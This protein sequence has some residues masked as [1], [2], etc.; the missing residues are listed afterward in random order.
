MRKIPIFTLLAAILL[1]GG[2]YLY[3]HASSKVDITFNFVVD[4]KGT[5][6]TVTGTI[7]GAG[8]KAVT[9]PLSKES[10]NAVKKGNRY[11]VEA[12]FY[13]KNKI[14]SDE[15]KELDGP[16]WSNNS[17]QGLLVNKVQVENIQALSDDF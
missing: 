6:N 17:N 3:Q 16:F 14:S 1:F 12:T 8:N 11:N 4:D 7:D 2:Y 10:W 15:A 5:D 9:L 13:N